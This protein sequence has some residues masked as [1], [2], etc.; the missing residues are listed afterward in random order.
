MKIYVASS[1]RN[2]R[3]PLVV[4]A[5]R[6]AGHE[7]Y[8]FRNPMAG[9]HGF[10]WSDIDPNWRSWSPEMFAG[11]LN[12]DTA[13]AGFAKDKAAMEWADACVMVLPCGRSASLEAGWAIGSGRPT[14]ILLADGE[15]EL[16]FKLA[17]LVTSDLGVVVDWIAGLQ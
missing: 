10:H 2:E 6:A 13:R 14:A 17:D 4:G 12:H 15:P 7:V 16:M 8:D 9:D 11:H 5:L 3:Q 1:W